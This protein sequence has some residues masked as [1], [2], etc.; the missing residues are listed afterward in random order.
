MPRAA[1]KPKAKRSFQDLFAKYETY[2]PEVEGFGNP[3]QWK[4]AFQDRMNLGEARETLR[5]KGPRGILGVSATATWEEIAKA[6]KKRIIE[7]HPDRCKVTG[8]T[9]EEATRLS[10]EVVAA[11][12]ILADEF[13][14]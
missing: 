10:K 1:A 7:V 8:L 6:F 4:A 11:Y 12:S 5:G 3:E 9:V 2:N 14:K 13:G